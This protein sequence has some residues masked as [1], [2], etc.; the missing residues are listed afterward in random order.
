MLQLLGAVVP[1]QDREHLEVDHALEQ[2]ADAFEQ[3]VR[4]E[5][6]RD[7]MRD[8]MQNSQRLCLA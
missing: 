6:G 7:L 8:L 5:D 3:V 4:I 1:E 2:C